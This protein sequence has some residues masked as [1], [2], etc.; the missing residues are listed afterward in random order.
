MC[1]GSPQTDDS[2]YFGVWIRLRVLV[3]NILIG[4]IFDLQSYCRCGKQ[5]RTMI[6][7][8]YDTKPSKVAGMD[9]K[10]KTRPFTPIDLLLLHLFFSSPHSQQNWTKFL[11]LDLHTQGDWCSPNKQISTDILLQTESICSCDC[12]GQIY[13]YFRF[14]WV[15]VHCDEFVSCLLSFNIFCSKMQLN[16]EESWKH[17]CQLYSVSYG[18]SSRAHLCVRNNR[19]VVRSTPS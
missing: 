12:F 4:K 1:W 11:L 7:C 6:R 3:L 5:A 15:S 19:M 8:V 10:N 14:W 18:E 17:K 16:D 2:V 9:K 13:S